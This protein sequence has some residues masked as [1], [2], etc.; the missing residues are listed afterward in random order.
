[1]FLS[2]SRDKTLY[3]KLTG[4]EGYRDHEMKWFPAWESHLLFGGWGGESE[5]SIDTSENCNSQT[6]CAHTLVEI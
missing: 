2:S 3:K 4:M 6:D 5:S 1:M